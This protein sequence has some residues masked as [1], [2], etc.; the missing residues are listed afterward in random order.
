MKYW[1]RSGLKLSIFPLKILIKLKKK[2]PIKQKKNHKTL[3]LKHKS[4]GNIPFVPCS[5][6]NLEVFIMP[7]CIRGKSSNILFR[8]IP[9]L[10]SIELH[11][12][13]WLLYIFVLLNSSNG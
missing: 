2:T 13:A 6:W 9:V 11:N 10:L 8:Y 4:V 12:E 7:F 5:N 1:I 3:A